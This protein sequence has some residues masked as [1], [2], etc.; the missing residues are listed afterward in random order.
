MH[1]MI[2][3]EFCLMWSKAFFMTYMISGWGFWYKIVILG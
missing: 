1:D 3:N 2:E